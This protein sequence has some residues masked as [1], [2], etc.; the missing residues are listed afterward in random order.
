MAGAA[1]ASPMRLLYV[2]DTLMV[3]GPGKTILNTWRTID[4]NRFDL[5]IAATK[6]DPGGRSL[7]L[8]AA[9][10]LGAQTVPLHIGPGIDIAAVWRLIRLIRQHRID[11]LQT[12]DMQTRRIGVIA[13]A[14]TGVRHITSV[15]G[16]I[17]N[18]RKEQLAKRLDARLIRWADAVIAVSDR[19]KQE[20]VAAGVPAEKITLLRNG[21]LLDDYAST[22]AGAS[23]RR[24]LG[25]SDDQ[26]V[27]S[28][29]GR[30]SPEKGHE[31]FLLAASAIAA[32][33]PDA[34]FLIVGDGP[35][36]SALKA[37]ARELGLA[38]RVIFTGHRSDL[39]SI[40]G[41]T[42]VLVISSFT[43]G[44]PNVL[45]EAFANGK[46]V[47]ATSVGGVPEVLQHGHTGW[48]VSPGDH[49]AI[50]D[51]VVALLKNP[52]ERSTMGA[53]GRRLI[54]DRFSFIHRTRAL[55]DLY[56]RRHAIV[57]R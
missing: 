13:A 16:W 32:D 52:H 12:H 25:L 18:D 50:A 56:T 14:L 24:E 30:L 41:I 4:R 39:A 6:P 20:L 45:L 42:S 2:R 43:E 57:G 15:H 7:F 49:A 3:C 34:R 33:C 22:D 53:A 23:L 40:Y 31:V 11:V 55:E 37:R 35:L 29:V 9:G 26:P 19:L 51:R 44:I 47:V 48:L 46:P 21:I 36:E 38:D 8:E 10:Q 17:F 28:I 27:V 5:T 54:E 1:Q